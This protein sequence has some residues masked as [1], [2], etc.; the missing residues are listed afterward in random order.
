M[1]YKFFPVLALGWLSY[2]AIVILFYPAGGDA[3]SY[4]YGIINDKIYNKIIKDKKGKIDM[5]LK[6]LFSISILFLIYYTYKIYYFAKILNFKEHKFLVAPDK[7]TDGLSWGFPGYYNHTIILAILYGII[8]SLYNWKFPLLL[9]SLWIII[10][11]LVNTIKY[12]S[13]FKLANTA[14]SYWCIYSA[15]L[16]VIFY[17]IN[18]YIN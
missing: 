4:Y 6:I 7:I 8:I 11:I 14:G 5:S 1:T 17:Y 15:L 3:L 10:G 18:P 9:I 12:N 2:L 13:P 16:I